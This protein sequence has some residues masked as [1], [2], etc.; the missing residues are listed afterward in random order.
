[1]TDLIGANEFENI[2]NAVADTHGLAE[3]IVLP[4]RG[5]VVYPNIVMPV[6]IGDNRALAAARA[7]MSANRTV[8]GVT[9]K[10][11]SLG[12]PGPADLFSVG[13]EM[14][15]GRM[16][17]MM[18]NQKTALAQGRRRMVIVEVMQNEPYLIVRAR[19]LGD[20]IE[21]PDEI[22]ILV[23]T[24]TNL[25]QNVVD[26]NDNLPDEVINYALSIDEPSWLGDFITST[27]TLPLDDRQ[28]VLETTNL[29][30]RLHFVASLVSREL[31]MLELKDEITGHVQQ[32]MARN[33]R[34]IYLREQMRAIQTELGEED[35]FQQE[36][37]D[38]REQIATAGLPQEVHERAVKEVT[39]LAIM[40]PMAP[41][42]GIIRTYLDWIVA[43]PWSKVS[44]DN[45]DLKRAQEMLDQ[46]HYGLPKI[47][48]RILEHI[49][50]RKLAPDK[51]KA[52][53]LCFVGPPGVGKTSLG[54]SIARALGREFVRVSLGGV[55]DE[56]EIRGHRRTYIGAMPGRV[57][58]TM[59][60]VGTINPVFMLDEIDKL[61]ADFRGD[62]AAALLE[63]LDPEQNR[64]YSDHYLELPYDLSRVIFITT[65]N[66]LYTMPPALLDRLEVIEFPGYTEEDKLDIARTFLIP[67][68]LESHGLKDAGLIFQQD[69][70]KTMIRD[71]TY[72]AGVRNLNREIGN[73]MRKVARR[74]AEEKPHP[75]RITSARVSEY[76]GPPEYVGL[77]ANDLDS[78]G[79]VT[80]LA[81][82]SGGGDIMLIEVSI[83]PGKGTMMLTGQLGEVMQESAQTA[84]SYLRARAAD[85]DIPSDD[86]EDFDIHIHVPEGAIPKDGPSAG[87][88]LA[89]AIISAFT[90]RK[91]RS[92]WAMTGEITLHGR[93]L[94][95]GGMR[96]KVL[97]ARRARIRNIILPALN[98]KDLVELSPAALR[99]MN[100]LFVDNMQQ[101]IEAVLLDPL[102]D[103]RQRDKNREKDETADEAKDA[104]SKAEKA[105][106]GKKKH[107]R[108]TSG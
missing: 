98:R 107:E 17:P 5:A 66:E 80:G 26:L 99:D 100:L 48:D 76:L 30:E 104:D 56:A 105:K 74:I 62:P 81:W 15:L 106:S 108:P 71:Y 36:I 73:V 22:D 11:P 78:V 92:N 18:D 57:L 53:I 41:E 25:F 103:G 101:V 29:N 44:E 65:A 83:L 61:G 16:I 93:V 85:F 40:P 46:D 20:T 86:F 37:N 33:Q 97:A 47:K 89:T 91:V 8:L 7:A 13:T 43:L 87:V 67:K 1:L 82:T 55:R 90:E 95:I 32:E 14:A 4:L 52:P 27:L 94:P 9:L 50:V 10:H 49:A 21:D 39:R 31:N 60:R 70:L 3:L 79:V 28:R 38:L 34:E 51:M 6:T 72:E 63:V 19:E 64:E 42:V 54:Q 45:L 69:A 84:M 68:Q 77:R 24:L 58:Q 59:R 35:I 88:T 12:A 23:Q 96:E 75:K 2:G 102:P